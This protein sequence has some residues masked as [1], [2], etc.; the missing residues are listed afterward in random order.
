[1]K[2]IILV[3]GFLAAT[4]TANAQGTQRFEDGIY[5]RP[6]TTKETPAT[7]TTEKD[8]DL[9]INGVGVY[10]FESME[11]GY[12][13]AYIPENIPK[14]SMVKVKNGVR[15]QMERIGI[16]ECDYEAFKTANGMYIL[17]RKG[18]G[19]FS[20]YSFHSK[21]VFELYQSETKFELELQRVVS[22]YQSKVM[23]AER[24][25]KRMEEKREIVEG[26]GF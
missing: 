25:R 12:Y 19:G 21:M 4:L 23:A 15:S 17:M 16:P 20:E 5:S 10:L 18:D 1:M 8:C 13:R 9:Y 2:K 7:S 24:A 3:F 6:A 22:D 26:L 14:E 11:K